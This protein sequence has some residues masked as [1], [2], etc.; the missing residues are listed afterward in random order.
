[1]EVTKNAVNLSHINVFYTKRDD[2]FRSVFRFFII[3][4]TYILFCDF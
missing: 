1:M 4:D 2:N 3:V